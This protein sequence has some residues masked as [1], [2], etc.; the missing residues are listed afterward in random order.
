[1]W[2]S[3]RGSRPSQ[4]PSRSYLTRV[5]IIGA[6]FGG[7]GAAKTFA[8]AQLAGVE[9]VVVLDKEVQITIGGSWRYAW[10][11]RVRKEDTTGPWR[12]PRR[13]SRDPFA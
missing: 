10:S 12:T 13:S 7:L 9:S 8:D 3:R 1:M 4:P 5:V 2:R 11:G 6:G